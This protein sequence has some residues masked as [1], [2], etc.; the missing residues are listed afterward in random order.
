M[1]ARVKPA[2]DDGDCCA[3][4]AHL[5]QIQL[6][7]S[8][9][10]AFSLRISPPEFSVV[11]IDGSL[12]KEGAERRS[13]HISCG[14]S[15]RKSRTG[16]AIGRSRLAALHCGVLS[17][18]TPLPAGHLRPR[19][20]RDNFPRLRSQ[21]GGLVSTNSRDHDCESWARAPLPIHAQFRLENAPQ[22]MGIRPP[23]PANPSV[24][25]R[26]KNYF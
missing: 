2:H 7:N 10:F 9:V 4:I 1:D 25:S 16:L 22:R 6:S 14:G 17:G 15:Q 19:G 13:A 20:V 12:E 5:F 8:H 21:P 3:F 26:I 23:Y 18:G 24:S 11:S